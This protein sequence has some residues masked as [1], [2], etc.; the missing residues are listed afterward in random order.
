[1]TL[2]LILNLTQSPATPEQLAEGV[3]DLPPSSKNQL[4]NLL[5]F[6]SLPSQTELVSRATDVAL[7][8]AT[9][10]NARHAM[11]DGAPFFMKSLEEA[12]ELQGIE[13]LFAFLTKETIEITMPNGD[14]KKIDVFKHTGFVNSRRNIR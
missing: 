4:D 1:M 5:T 14:I 8:A 7:L 9:I 10:S 2:N 3:V 11:I 12:L 6:D 13:P